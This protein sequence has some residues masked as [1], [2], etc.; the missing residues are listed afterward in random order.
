MPITIVVGGGLAGLTCTL[1]SAQ[2]GPV[3][4]IE[5]AKVGGNSS[6]ATSGINCA[7]D[8]SDIKSF[9]NDVAMSG[10][11]TQDKILATM[12]VHNSPEAIKWLEN[13]D[14][15]FGKPV[16]LGGHSR[17]RTLR[18]IDKDGNILPVGFTLTNTLKQLCQTNPMVQILEGHQV[19][20]LLQNEKGKVVGVVCQVENENKVIKS[21][22]VVITTGG[23]AYSNTHNRYLK[24]YAPHLCSMPTT[25][26]DT[27]IGS[28][29]DLV[30]SVGGQLINMNSIQLHPTGFVDPEN[31]EAMTK[32][33]APEALRGL[34][35][36]LV[37]HLGLRFIDELTTRDKLVQAIEQYCLKGQATIILDQQMTESFSPS[38]TKFYISKGLLRKV[39]NIE[40]LICQSGPNQFTL[41]NISQSLKG[42]EPPFYFGTITPVVHYTQGGAKV[43]QH[44]QV[45]DCYNL[46]IKGLY[47]A[48]EATGGVHGD[49]RLGGCSLLECVVFGLIAAR[50]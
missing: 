14:I 18:P 6:K 15:V 41:L 33:L 27:S 2:F 21:D 35:G 37:N 4:L 24:E 50:Y 16:K 20:C 42:M 26:G 34:G 7:M 40:E 22:K 47:A 25:N 12:L 49:N 38:F 1:E 29:L 44:A 28:G 5:K 23:Y 36:R 46:P 9:Y 3:F 39:T 8:E 17:P 31:P 32:F 13:K 43:N 10:G 11:P 30:R 19:K 45:L 48:G